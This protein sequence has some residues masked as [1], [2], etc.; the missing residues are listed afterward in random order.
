MANTNKHTDEELLQKLKD[1]YKNWGN[2]LS[3]TIKKCDD[4]AYPEKYSRRFGS[5]PN[6]RELASVNKRKYD[7]TKDKIC[8]NIREV[9]RNNKRTLAK[10]INKTP[11]RKSNKTITELRKDA[12]LIFQDYNSGKGVGKSKILMIEELRN[13]RNLGIYTSKEN[14]EK[15][16]SYTENEY[17]YIFGL[18]N[19]RRIAGYKNYTNRNENMWSNMTEY[20]TFSEWSKNCEDY[21][22][23][24]K[25]YVYRISMD[26]NK[27]YIG[28]TVD[29]GRRIGEHSVRDKVDNSEVNNLYVE[30]YSS[31]EDAKERERELFFETGI[32]YD[33]KEVYGGK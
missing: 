20:Y 24:A 18:S 4:M 2:T 17:K 13:L 30:S 19:A 15:Y 5:I 29:L 16:T 12:G 27:F 1:L 8:E 23:S 26:G 33:T 9:E 10:N 21:I 6:A 3:S 25:C 31:I 28:Q 14:I 7:V 22:Q 11:L 32:E